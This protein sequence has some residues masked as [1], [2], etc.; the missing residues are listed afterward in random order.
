[1]LVS[2]ILKSKSD[3]GIVTVDPAASVAE[4]AKLLS[5][6]RIG[7]VVVSSDGK[8]ADGI[9]SERDIVREL[10]KSG[11]ACLTTNAGAIMTAEIVGC[12]LSDTSD[13]VL[14]A[15]TKGRFRHMP[16]VEGGEMVG[17]ISIGDVVKAQLSELEMEKTAL[18]DMIKGF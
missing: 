1:M 13:A 10:S 17:L 16:V 11:A 5:A 9:L 12:G 6:R 8:T 3:D 15:M 7:A 18:E 2:Q 4:A 14:A